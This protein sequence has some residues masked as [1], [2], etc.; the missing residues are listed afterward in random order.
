MTSTNKPKAA[1]WIIAVMAL[2][3]NLIGV[4]K[5]LAQAYMTDE[6]K[7]ILPEAERALYENVPLWVTSA[8]A[9]AVFGGILA[10]IALLMRKKIA[11]PLFLVSL[12]AILV[13]MIYNF[14]LSGAIDIYDP[15]V[16]V[17]PVMIILIGVFLYLHSK[18]SITKGWLN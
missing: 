1:F 17:L 7:A 11:K 10:S 13:E 3:W 6:A 8:F 5:Y 14:F 15:K 12:I 16:M 18:K 2:I 4:M 9:I